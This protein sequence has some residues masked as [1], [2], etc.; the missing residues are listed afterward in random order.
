VR[1]PPAPVPIVRRESETARLVEWRKLLRV[2][3]RR[4]S[5]LGCRLEELHAYARWASSAERGSLPATLYVI[6]VWPESVGST[7]VVS[8]RTRAATPIADVRVVTPITEQSVRDLVS[9]LAR[10]HA[11]HYRVDRHAHTLTFATAE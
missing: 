8:K 9:K 5:D 1:G 7:S 2:Y 11:G 10:D 3:R 6:T 4:A